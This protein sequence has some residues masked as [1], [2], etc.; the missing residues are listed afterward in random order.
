[1]QGSAYLEADGNAASKGI[2][3]PFAGRENLTLQPP[4]LVFIL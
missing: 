1:M 2:S 4:G 3:P